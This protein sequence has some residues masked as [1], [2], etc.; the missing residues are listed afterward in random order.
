LFRLDACQ[1][2]RSGALEQLDWLE[3]GFGTRFSLS[4][5]DTSALATLKQVHSNR[6]VVAETGGL[7][8]EGDALISNRPGIALAIRTAD[9]LPILIADTRHRAIAAVHAGWRG[10]VQEIVRETLA[11][12]ETQF[13]TRPEDLIVAIG[14][15]IGVC[16]YEVGPEVASQLASFFPERTDMSGQ[17]RVDLAETI[18]RQLRRYGGSLGQIDPSGLCTYCLAGSFHSYRRDGE[19]AGRMVSSI[20]IR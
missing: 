5:P 1:V 8:G 19:A 16:C 10:T 18:G 17:T 15:G 12:M 11:A 7:L 14:P 2:Y 6:V 9:C 4:W 13:G 20:Q 3:H